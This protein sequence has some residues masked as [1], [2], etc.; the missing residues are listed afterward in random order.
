MALSHDEGVN[1]A[2]FRTS[3]L[4]GASE[5]LELDAEEDREIIGWKV[6]LHN[7]DGS[8]TAVVNG[9]AYIGNDPVPTGPGMNQGE[10]FYCSFDFVATEDDTNG[11]GKAAMQDGSVIL[12]EGQTFA[13]DRHVTLSLYANERSGGDDGVNVELVVYYREV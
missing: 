5:E 12:P 13:W 1:T 2:I 7:L 9:R 4:S 11:V 8:E 10:Q 6:T 3:S